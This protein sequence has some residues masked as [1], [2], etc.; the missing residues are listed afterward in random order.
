MNELICCANVRFQDAAVQNHD[1]RPT[2]T[3]S[4]YLKD[5]EFRNIDNDIHC[6]EKYGVGQKII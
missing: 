2:A 5:M 6:L 1:P 4:R 3:K